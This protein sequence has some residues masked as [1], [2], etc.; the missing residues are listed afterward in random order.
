MVLINQTLVPHQCQP[1]RGSQDSDE[2]VPGGGP[3]K[4]VRGLG[5]RNEIHACIVQGCS[6]R[7][8][9][10]AAEVWK[11][12]EQ[13]LSGLTHFWIRLYSKDTVA[14]LQQQAGKDFRTGSNVG[15]HMPWCEPTFRLQH[16]HGF[17]RIAGSI[18]DI[19]LD[20]IG[21]SAGGVG[22]RH[23]GVQFQLARKPILT[24]G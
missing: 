14:I 12:G 7:L 5:G 6:L 4:P 13:P 22:S 11:L 17:G 8:S 18:A 3:I 23:S 20:P 15:N 21:K 1:P 9:G 24:A 16:A 19:V 10:H 2:L